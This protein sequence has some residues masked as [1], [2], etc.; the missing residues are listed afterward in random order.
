MIVDTHVHIWDEK[1]CSREMLDAIF[2][3]R[4]T[5]PTDSTAQRRLMPIP[6]EAW[7]EELR[8]AL[9]KAIVIGIDITRV[10]GTRL[11]D[12][13]LLEFI[14][15]DPDLL[16]AYTGVEP[17]DENN[18][19][20]EE[21]L[22]EVEKSVNEYGFKGVKLMPVHGNYY[23]NN[24]KLYPLY[25]KCLDLRI[26]ILFHLAGSSFPKAMLKYADPIVLDEVA[27]DFPELRMGLA[28]FGYPW[29]ETC[30]VLLQRNRNLFVDISEVLYRP[31]WVASGLQ[32]AKE[33]GVLDRIFFATDG[34]GVCRPVEKYVEWCRTGLNE[35]CKNSG[36][37]TF[38][39]G[40]I[41]GLLGDNAVKFLGL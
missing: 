30:C 22:D 20:K 10:F 13:F 7:L 16:L 28:H 26:P 1:Y 17:L 34:P 38:T 27:V 31:R 2:A 32:L 8:G 39:Q 5:L 40:E 3:H 4:A 14:K 11:P 24:K 21:V 35:L 37:P 25:E 23:A 33:Y 12:Q 19:F 18:N 9:D 29:A 6:M 41:D 15:M 36:L